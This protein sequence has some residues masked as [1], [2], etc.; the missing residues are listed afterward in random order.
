MAGTTLTPVAEEPFLRQDE[1]L[2]ALAA[3]SDTNHLVIYCGAGVSIDRTG[4]TWSALLRGVYKRAR[5]GL[6]DKS[7]N[8][9]SV[10]F[11]LDQ[12]E[13]PREA[14]SVLIE[15]FKQ[16]GQP[17]NDF[18]THKLHDILY[19]QNGWSRGFMLR[20]L[21]QF[22]L[23]AASASRNILIITTN[24][25]SYIEDEFVV[26]YDDM[27]NKGL[28]KANLPGLRRRPLVAGGAPYTIVRPKGRQSSW[29][30]IVYLHGRVD[31]KDA[32]PEGQI[33]LSENSYAATIRQSTSILESA[34][35]GD[36]KGVL[37]LGAS[38]TDAPLINALS[39]TRQKAGKRFALVTMPTA[40]DRASS[41]TTDHINTKTVAQALRKR[42]DHLGITILNP[43]SHH[44]SSQFLEELRVSCSARDKTNDPTFYGDIDHG[45]SYSSRLAAWHE[46]WAARKNT[47]DP[48]YAYTVLSSG[49]ETGIRLALKP[50]ASKGERFRAEIW[51][52]KNPRSDNRTLTLWATST[53]PI[54]D[55]SVLRTEPIR[56]HSN[57]ASVRA[58]T[59]GRPLRLG[60]EDLDF[61]SGASRWQTFFSM[62]I[63]INVEIKIDGNTD[64]AYVPVGVIT[65]TSDL[66][67]ITPNSEGTLSTFSDQGSLTVADYE[68]LKRQLI[69]MGRRVLGTTD[70]PAFP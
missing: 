8:H 25:D 26:Q 51:V 65:L 32:P 64:S 4:V 42:G 46:L 27:A 49:L 38:I 24:Y 7:P 48:D 41:A 10:D 60:I 56:R 1:T 2:G 31:S 23:A 29:V 9:D 39:N 58:F 14:A 61:P 15:S 12:L 28:P 5:A 17:E 21:V 63:F 45:I 34:F 30:E 69:G 3:L 44:Q 36:E 11:L 37:V 52:R 43:M 40:L 70:D 50:K 59:D 55:R 16:P 67:L 18:L 20:N 68:T 47:L 13:N 66:S 22:S 54:N 57:N 53:G 33:V 19:E 62:P 35:S 6:P